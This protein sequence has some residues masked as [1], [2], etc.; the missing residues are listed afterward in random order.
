[1]RKILSIIR[2]EFQ[3]IRRDRPMLAILFVVP[4]VQ[5]LV[6][7][8]V[9]SSEVKNVPT[10]IC[11]MDRSPDSRDLIARVIHSGYFDVR[12]FE[13]QMSEMTKYLDLNKATLAIVIPQEFSRNLRKN[14]PTQIQILMD[15]QD[16]NSAVIA[17]GY[18]GGIL[19]SFISDRLHR[20]MIEYAGQVDIHLVTPVVRIWYNE[21]LK[22]SHFMVPGIV[23]FLLT[24][25]TSLVSAM[26]L[27]RERELGTLEQLLVAPIKKHELLIGKLV[28]FALLGFVVF[29]LGIA[30]ARIWYHIPIVGN[31]GIIA[32]FAFLY[33]FSTLGI[34]LFVSA[35]SHTQQQ[36]MF[37]TMFLLV[38]FI[39]MSGFFVPIENMPKTLQYLT[40][41][42][43]MRYFILVVREVFIKGA[44][45]HH[46]Y[47]QGIALLIFGALIFS[48]AAIRF[49][50]RLK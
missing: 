16:S 9:V 11:D 34:G 33:L 42:N 30:F 20:Q 6:L 10:V 15:G 4:I 19:E 38:F 49:Q 14:V 17:M 28:P 23:V 3:Q 29:A 43:P 36:A 8:Y 2:K 47:L 44:N 40:Y 18:I 41:L 22:Y 5:L 31:L 46:L 50:K 45:L 35:S 24:M 32:L 7:G 37:M 12:Y 21:D 27:V 13:P 25:V 26:G 39:L 1:M 48:L